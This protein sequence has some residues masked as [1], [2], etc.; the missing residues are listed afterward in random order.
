MNF[1]K[2]L[3]KNKNVSNE[4]ET[5]NQIN[6]STIEIEN[7]N[8]ENEIDRNLFKAS[9]EELDNLRI[10][11]MENNISLLQRINNDIDFFCSRD[12]E[13]KGFKDCVQ[14]SDLLNKEMNRK[15]IIADFRRLL[16]KSI[17]DIEL[18]VNEID[19]RIKTYESAGM[20]ESVTNF[21]S[22]MNEYD[23]YKN[24]LQNLLT[25][26]NSLLDKI[27]YCL[28]SYDIGFNNGLKNNDNEL[29]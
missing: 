13:A 21:T 24:E 29:K 16:E 9:Q 27:Q 2:F 22:I 28:L 23:E 10:N 15:L 25:S 8:L 18:R 20:T 26:E 1:L 3:F 5:S 17:K 6:D 11:N 4:F 14:N 7:N 12:L 19:K